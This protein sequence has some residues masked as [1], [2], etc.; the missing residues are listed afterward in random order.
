MYYFKDMHASTF[1]AMCRSTDGKTKTN[2]CKNNGFVSAYS[3]TNTEE[4]YAE[5]FS[6]WALTKI[7]KDTQYLA[8]YR[9]IQAQTTT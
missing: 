9:D 2:A 8:Y 3:Q 1:E 4:D 5:T 7:S 6:R